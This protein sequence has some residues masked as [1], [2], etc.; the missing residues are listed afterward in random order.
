VAAETQPAGATT[1][2]TAE[3]GTSD[4]VTKTLPDSNAGNTGSDPGVSPAPTRRNG[5]LGETGDAT[6]RLIILGGVALLV[7]AVVV[8]FTGR[9]EP[10]PATAGGLGSALATP[11]PRRRTRRARR[12]DGWENGVPLNPT[13]RELARRRAGISAYSYDSYL[14]G[15]PEA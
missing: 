2:T 6:R 11:A 9:D 14:D 13:K 4:P 15:G 8:A 7:G 12:A 3:A 5:Q 1:S 10:R